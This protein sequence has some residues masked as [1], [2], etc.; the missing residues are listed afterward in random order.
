M[1]E[2]HTPAIDGN[3][4]VVRTYMDPDRSPVDYHHDALAYW[5]D[6]RGEDWAPSWKDVSLLDFAPNVIPLISVTDITPEPL[7]SIYRFWGTKLTEIHGGDYSGK[8][9]NLV[10]PKQLGLANTGGCGRLV[11]E[12]KP[13]LEIKEFRNQRGLMGRAMVLRL[14][15]SDDG[16]T[17]N[18][19]VN[20]YYFEPAKDNQ[21]MADFFA[22]VFATLD[23][24]AQ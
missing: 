3:I 2:D 15:L 19:G 13:H 11:G 9:P 8:P 24:N 14:P 22:G 17:V 5:N 4:D 6:V 10:P 1:G 7:S 21:P 20:V 18:H 23:A 16:E 12:R